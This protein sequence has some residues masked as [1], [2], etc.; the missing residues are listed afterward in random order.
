[1]N[2]DDRAQQPP[3]QSG[4]FLAGLPIYDCNG[5][6]LGVVSADGVLEQDLMMTVGHM[7]RRDVAVPVSAIARSDAHGVYLSQT[8]QEIEDLMLGGWSNLG[9]VDLNTS[10]PDT[11]W[12]ASGPAS[13]PDTSPE[14]RG[15]AESAE[16]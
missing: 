7:L 6:H 5:E 10:E 9:D 2:A 1:M 11:G 3:N 4:D 16:S 15:G 14:Q 13:A 12:P 8:K